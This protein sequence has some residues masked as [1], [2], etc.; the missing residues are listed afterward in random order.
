MRGA[1]QLIAPGW[2]NL[3]QRQSWEKALQSPEEEDKEGLGGE[4]EEEE[5]RGKEEGVYVSL[6]SIL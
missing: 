1:G 4:K 2:E 3:G 5:R 6:A